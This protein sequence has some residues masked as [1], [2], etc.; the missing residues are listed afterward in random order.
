MINFKEGNLE[1]TI[2]NN[3]NI[4]ITWRGR[5]EDRDPS[6]LLNPYLKNLCNNLIGKNIEVYFS[7]LEYMNSSTVSP[8]IQ[9]IK[10][11][12]GQNITTLIKFK[13][14]STWQISSFKAIEIIAFTMDFIKVIGV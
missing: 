11:L 5:S 6:S 14:S 2:E 10:N 4:I 3:E 9:F 1:I 12:N 7:K 8:I 13:K